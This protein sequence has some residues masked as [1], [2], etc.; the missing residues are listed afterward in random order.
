MPRN[1]GQVAHPPLPIDEPPGHRVEVHRR[2]TRRVDRD[3]ASRYVG[4]AQQGDN[5]V[6]VVTAHPLPASRVSTAPSM[7]SL[8]P[9]T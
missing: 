5:E 2:Q 3:E 6:R 8:E 7:G 4:R 9:G 1:I